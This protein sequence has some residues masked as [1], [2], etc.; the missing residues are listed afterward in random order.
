MKITLEST[1]QVV[2]LE[3]VGGESIA[4]RIWEGTTDTGTPVV[5]FIARI[6]PAIA[7]K[8][9]TPAVLEEFGSQL[10]ECRTPTAA[11]QSIP[12]RLIL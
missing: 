3:T 2:E 10:R 8:D 4:A 11:V 5:C 7:E 9:L 1:P 12:L 6:S